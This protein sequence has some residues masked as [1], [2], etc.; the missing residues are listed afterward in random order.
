V[1]VTNIDEHIKTMQGT[2]LNIK[3]QMPDNVQDGD[4]Q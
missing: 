3:A 4:E 2:M 1:V